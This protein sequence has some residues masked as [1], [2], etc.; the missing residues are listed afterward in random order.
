MIA[1]CMHINSMMMH[2]LTCV[3]NSSMH[4]S[5]RLWFS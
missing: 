5:S 3:T 2:V 4:I 1:T